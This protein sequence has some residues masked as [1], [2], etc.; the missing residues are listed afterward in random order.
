ML[1]LKELGHCGGEDLSCGWLCGGKRLLIWVESLS[2]TKSLKDQF[3]LSSGLSLAHR[4][5]SGEGYV[6]N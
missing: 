6:N 5:Y 2:L 3:Y 1:L 4:I